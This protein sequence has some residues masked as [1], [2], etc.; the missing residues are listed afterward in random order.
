MNWKHWAKLAAIGLV[1]VVIDIKTKG[2]I[3]SLLASIPVVGGF[4]TS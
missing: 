3:R 2:K 1:F 4:L